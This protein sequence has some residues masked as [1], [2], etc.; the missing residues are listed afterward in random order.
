MMKCTPEWLK[1][2]LEEFRNY[3][4]ETQRRILGELMYDKVR[5]SNLVKDEKQVSKITG[6]L[7]DVEIL[8]LEEI[9]EALNIDSV[10]E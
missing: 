7:I 10:F 3:D 8:E 9:V 2:N 1:D 6:M 4:N 5:K